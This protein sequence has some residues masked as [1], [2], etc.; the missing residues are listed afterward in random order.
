M[1]IIY[2]IVFGV[3]VF[4]VTYAIGLGICHMCEERNK[5][6]FANLPREVLLTH[7]QSNPVYMSHYC[8]MVMGGVSP[9]R[10][11]ELIVDR[12]LVE[13]GLI[14]YRKAET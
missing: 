6:A 11:S 12:M 14:G 4:A 10:A 2:S 13:R 3:L 7:A 5:R 8:T 1:I 9:E